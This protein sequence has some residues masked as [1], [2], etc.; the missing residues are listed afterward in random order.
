[1]AYHRRAAPAQPAWLRRRPLGLLVGAALLLL[2]LSGVVCVWVGS[3]AIPPDVALRILAA[4]LVPSWRADIPPEY[5]A[6]LWQIRLPRIAL[7]AVAGAALAGA[8]TAYQGLFRNPLADP[9]LIGV[10]SGAGLGALS[11]QAL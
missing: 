7:V 3:V 4:G 8:G 9:F 10:A 11:V 6:I 5:A 1:M 2:A